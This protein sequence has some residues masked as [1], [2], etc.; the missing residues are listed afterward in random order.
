MLSKILSKIYEEKEYTSKWKKCGCR[1]DYHHIYDWKYQKSI[2]GWKN[3]SKVLKKNSKTFKELDIIKTLQVS[4]VDQAFLDE[5]KMR[6]RII[7]TTTSMLG[8]INKYVDS[9][10][11]SIEILKTIQMLSK[12]LSKAY[13]EKGIY[14]SVFGKCVYRS[15]YNHIYAWNFKKKKQRAKKHFKCFKKKVQYEN[16][17]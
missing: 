14:K 12:V 7:T 10:Y 8:A 13:E 9:P 4:V 11:S 3:N 1:S 17:I 16:K 5:K 6:I 15:D 2:E